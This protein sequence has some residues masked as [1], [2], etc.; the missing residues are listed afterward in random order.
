MGWWNT[1]GRLISRYTQPAGVFEAGAA[2][3]N[4]CFVW[5]KTGFLDAVFCKQTVS[6]PNWRF[7]QLR[8]CDWIAPRGEI[9]HPSAQLANLSFDGAKIFMFV[10]S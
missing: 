4:P 2:S 5:K 6:L 3:R 7:T 1:P 9:I 8:G 10:P